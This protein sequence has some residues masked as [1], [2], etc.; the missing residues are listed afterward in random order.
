MPSEA[1]RYVI[2][3]NRMRW[4]M[5]HRAMLCLPWPKPWPKPW[6]HAYVQARSSEWPPS[7]VH[8]APAAALC[9]GEGAAVEG[10]M[11]WSYSH[12]GGDATRCFPRD[13]RA[14]REPQAAGRCQSILFAGVGPLRGPLVG[15]PAGAPWGRGGPL[16]VPR[17]A[18]GSRGGAESRHPAKP[19]HRQGK[20]LGKPACAVGSAAGLGVRR[21]ACLAG[22]GSASSAAVTVERL[23]CAPR[24]L[25]RRYPVLAGGPVF[26][27]RPADGVSGV[28]V[29]VAGD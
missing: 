10:G 18:K 25:P 2:A 26:D 22:A 7:G 14:A 1:W 23:R 16:G 24:P 17:D 28:G 6:P 20:P 3:C 21:V 8:G 15:S 19:G 27:N 13:R 29:V 4:V 9:W 5:V 11:A 12:G